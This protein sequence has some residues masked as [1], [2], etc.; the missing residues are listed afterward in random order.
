MQRIRILLVVAI[1]VLI[2]GTAFAQGFPVDIPGTGVHFFLYRYEGTDIPF[3]KINA[4]WA[5]LSSAFSHWV[6]MGQDPDALTADDVRILTDQ[7]GGAHLFIK[8]QF[9]VEVDEYHAK[10]NKTTPEKLAEI[11]AENLRRGVEEF[12]A[13]NVLME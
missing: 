11:W 10:L 7:A 6:D 9:I 5:N 2:A 3:Q 1:V 13:V 8:D 12:V 4:I